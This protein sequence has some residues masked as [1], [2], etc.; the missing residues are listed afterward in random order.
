MPAGRAHVR[1]LDAQRRELDVDRERWP[2]R[3]AGSRRRSV[4]ASWGRQ[5]RGQSVAEW[6]RGLGVAA[7][8]AASGGGGVLRADWGRPRGQPAVGGRA[9]SR[10]QS[11]RTARGLGAAARIAGGGACARTRGGRADSRRRSVHVN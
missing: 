8:W 10:R 1:R 3:R 9:G 5:S 11:R 7:A 6:A 2:C 4:R